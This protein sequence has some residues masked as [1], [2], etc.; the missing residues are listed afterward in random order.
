MKDNIKYLE[1]I[2]NNIQESVNN[3]KIVFEKI[4]EN[5]E[6]IKNNIQKLFTKLRNEL[7][8]R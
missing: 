6:E 4:N 8:K 1:E 3:L 2:S 5:K 7:N